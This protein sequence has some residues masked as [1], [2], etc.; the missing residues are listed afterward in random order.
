MKIIRTLALALLLA[1]QIATPAAA[2]DPERIAI[3]PQS[4]GGAIILKAALLPIPPGHRTSYRIGL[5]E[6]RS[7]RAADDG[8]ALWRQSDLPGAD[9]APSSTAIWFSTVRPGTY[10]FRDLSRQDFWALCFNE[11]SLQFTV[12]PGEVVYLGEMDVRRHVAELER[13]AIESGRIIGA[14]RAARPFL[15]PGVAAGFGAGGRSRPCRGCGDDARAHAAHDGGAESGGAHP[16]PVRHR[17]RPVR[18]AA[19]LRRLFPAA[20]TP[21]IRRLRPPLRPSARSECRAPPLWPRPRPRR[22]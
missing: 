9:A 2:A 16:G 12:R 5:Q 7:G 1:A 3:T 13:M 8:R 22:G 20:R 17:Q 14:S 10:A 19:H 15:R 11:D 21:A 6:L 18:H 4:S